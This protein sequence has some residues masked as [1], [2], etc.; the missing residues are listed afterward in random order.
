MTEMRTR[1]DRRYDHSLRVS[2]IPNRQVKTVFRG[3][4]LARSMNLPVAAAASGIKA[5]VQN[6]LDGGLVTG[7]VPAKL[8]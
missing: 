2:R 3:K 8:N 4:I 1:N 6:R 5:I 7:A